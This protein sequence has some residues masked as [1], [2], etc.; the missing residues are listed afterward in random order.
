MY[1]MYDQFGPTS[2]ICFDYVNDPHARK[3]HNDKRNKALESLSSVTL[4][5][6]VDNSRLLSMDD[7]SHTLILVKRMSKEMKILSPE[8]DYT[9]IALAVNPRVELVS[10]A[11]EDKVR[12]R[13][14]EQSRAE[15]LQLYRQLASVASTRCIAGLAFEALAHYILQRRINIDLVPMV[16]KE[17]PESGEGK[18]MPRWQSNRGGSG[19]GTPCDITPLKTKVYEGSSLDQIEDGW[20]YVPQSKNQVA[21]DSFIM[22]NGNLYIFQCSIGEDHPIKEGILDFFS[23]EYLPPQT[24]W[25]FIFVIPSDGS[26]IKCP[27]PRKIVLKNLFAQMKLYTMTLD[28]SGDAT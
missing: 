6:M 3:R 28:V 22:A 27:Q 10:P 23:Q 26:G 9:N 21:F 18:N 19:G 11:I 25:Y 8:D 16:K 17:S 20:Y 2:R 12:V 14:W 7:L 13:L 24:N 15:R 1:E 4:H 5:Q